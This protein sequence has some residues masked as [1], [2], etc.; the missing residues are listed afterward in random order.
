MAT[1]APAV[2][3]VNLPVLILGAALAL[4]G[5]GV[6][7]LSNDQVLASSLPETQSTLVLAAARRL[8]VFDRLLDP[9]IGEGT[10]ARGDAPSIRFLPLTR[11]IQRECDEPRLDLSRSASLR[12][13]PEAALRWIALALAT[14]AVALAVARL[15]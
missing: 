5:F 9:Q 1:A 15:R 3:R 13:A 2:R 8:R 6:T 11:H 4:A 14:F 10:A 12:S 7:L